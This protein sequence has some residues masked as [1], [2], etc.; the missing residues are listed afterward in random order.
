MKYILTEILDISKISE[1]LESFTAVTGL[2]S[3]LIDLDGNIIAKT[4]S[5]KICS[6]FHH[7]NPASERNCK[8]SNT[9]LAGQ[10][11]Q[12]GRFTT[13]TCLNGLIDVV[14]PIVVHDQKI[15]ML[16]IGQFFHEKPDESFFKSQAERFWLDEA[17]YLSALSL[18]PIINEKDL[19]AKLDLLLKMT[20]LIAALGFARIQEME[21]RKT[22]SASEK[23]FRAVVE[24]SLTGIFIL[25][26]K[27][28]T[29]ING[30]FAE[31]FGYTEEE[32]LNTLTPGDLFPSENLSIFTNILQNH[33]EDNSKI[34]QGVEKGLRK[35]GST[36][37]IEIHG[38]LIEIED[39]LVLT[40]NILD[41]SQKI[42]AERELMRQ[43]KRIE[44]LRSIDLDLLLAKSGRE[45]IKSVLRKLREIIPCTNAIVQ[46]FD[47]DVKYA[48]QY[49][50]NSDFEIKI[51]PEV[52]L[53]ETEALSKL[54]N[55]Q[56]L[57]LN[58]WDQI[59]D[60][61]SQVARMYYDQGIRSAVV[62]PIKINDA[63]FGTLGVSSTIPNNFNTEH[64]E[65]L[66]EISGQLAIALKN[67]LL[68]E[69]LQQHASR[70]EAAQRIGNIGTW[71]V[72]L[73]TRE[74]VWS[75]EQYRMH[76]LDPDTFIPTRDNLFEMVHPD[77]QKIVI[78][79]AN[80]AITNR[81]PILFEVRVMIPNKGVRIH[82]VQTEVQVDE[83]NNPIK[84]IGLAQ[85]ITEKKKAEAQLKESKEKL[86]LQ[87]DELLSLMSK[88]TWINSD[89][90]I[91]IQEITQ[92]CSSI[93]KTG[94]VSV[95]RYGKD[96]KDLTIIDVFEIA[97]NCH[98][99]GEKLPSLDFPFSTKHQ[100][101]NT[102]INIEDLAD[103]STISKIA[104]DYFK[105]H[106][107][108]A[109]LN[110]HIWVGRNVWG[111]LSFEETENKRNWTKEDERLIT[112]MA[113]MISLAFEIKERKSAESKLKKHGAQLEELVR[114]RTIDLEIKNLELKDKNLEL[115]R[116]ND[117]F[118]NREFRIKELK[119][120]IKELKAIMK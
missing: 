20:E 34:L 91:A 61:L 93:I 4:D 44:V 16:I 33:K 103:N 17:D 2:A 18:V 96:Y 114:Q 67:D 80:E 90:K 72:N 48:D 57:V 81:K 49:E 30:Q 88:G 13:Y 41:V 79:K 95:W 83:N 115:A 37:W 75:N 66:E 53:D 19:E 27:K 59:I 82:Q 117:L 108:R 38:T 111:I 77:D 21:N 97:G 85:D 99:A 104:L 29:Y 105:K 6:E 78:E 102:I 106:N 23:R 92:V 55:G 64:A 109:L 87:N 69:E 63:L 36:I 73:K 39:R 84:L 43:K 12:E 25:D 70:L 65:I 68:R 26:N 3:S 100:G 14:V 52:P 32:V 35:D 46:Q 42:K 74:V 118:V 11:S 110:V 28:F 45:I 62:A 94:R 56:T 120:K 51:D 7:K 101:A 113:T 47:K 116:F 60:Q 15:G 98:S 89:F 9:T 76:G 24:Q 58:D 86:Q 54:K 71:E 22:I 119:E 31:L 10:Y 8:I 40:G 5:Q 107:I 112:S 50:V 1:L